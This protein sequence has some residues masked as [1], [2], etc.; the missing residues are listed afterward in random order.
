MSEKKKGIELLPK[1]GKL[2]N[3][4]H[5][6]LIRSLRAEITLKQVRRN[7]ADFTLV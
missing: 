1:E 4:S 3:V 2:R 7:L 6:F 5:P